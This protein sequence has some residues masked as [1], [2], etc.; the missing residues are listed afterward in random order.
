MLKID[1]SYKSLKDFLPKADEYVE[2]WIKKP[3]S[4]A[5]GASLL[6][7]VAC[8]ILVGSMFFWA[9]QIAPAFASQQTDQDELQ[10]AR[11]GLQTIKRMIGDE[12]AWSRSIQEEYNRLSI[13]KDTDNQLSSLPDNNN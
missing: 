2:R 5:L 7:F 4:F 6:G 3:T 10:R 8:M 12:Q 9:S 11:T 1:Q 13:E